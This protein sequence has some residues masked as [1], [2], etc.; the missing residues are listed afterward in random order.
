V[1]VVLRR[2]KLDA[3]AMKRIYDTVTMKNPLQLKF[4]FAL[5]T[6]RM[7]GQAIFDRFGIRLSKA[8]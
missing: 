7:V 6:A 5:W 1:V 3:K 8:R 2:P 4:T